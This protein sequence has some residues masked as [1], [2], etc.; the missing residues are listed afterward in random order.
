MTA[1]LS[2]GWYHPR[3]GRALRPEVIDGAMDVAGVLMRAGVTAPLVQRV[4]LKVRQFMAL[5]DPQMQGLTA[6]GDR[7]RTALS[8]RLDRY[9]GQVPELDGFLQD[10]VE[11]LK[12]PADVLALYLH[13][14]HVTRMMQLLALA[15]GGRRR[16]RRVGSAKQ[17]SRAKK[18][19][20]RSHK[21][22]QAKSRKRVRH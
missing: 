13:L 17:G 19:R 14:I 5:A 12:A 22:Q 11:H 9:S 2:R 10:C 4:A 8:A 15:V 1:Y 3:G 18:A 21:G 6:F 20:P 7:E 16:A